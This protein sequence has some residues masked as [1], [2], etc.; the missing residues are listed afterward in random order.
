MEHVD[1]EVQPKT[2][3]LRASDHGEGVPRACLDAE[4]PDVVEIVY[5]DRRVSDMFVED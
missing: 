5:V 3:D 4:P 2:V 1:I